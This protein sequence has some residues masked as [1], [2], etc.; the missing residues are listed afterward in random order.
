MKNDVVEKAF[1]AEYI[2]RRSLCINSTTTFDDSSEPRAHGLVDGRRRDG[3]SRAN[4][5][6]PTS[7]SRIVR[8][9]D[10]SRDF[11]MNWRRF[12]DRDRYSSANSS[13]TS[14]PRVYLLSR[15]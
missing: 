7:A 12:D 11:S 2:I 6:V 1:S 15:F 9:R 13:S 5:D 4:C 3:D 8:D 14:F 10:S